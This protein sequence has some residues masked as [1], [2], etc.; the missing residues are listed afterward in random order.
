MKRNLTDLF[1]KTVD[2]PTDKRI[3]IY[4]QKIT[5]LTLRVTP[6]GK[7]TFTFTYRM[8]GNKIKRRLQ[9]G[10]YPAVLLADAREKCIQAMRD[11]NNNIDPGL[12]VKDTK[13]TPLIKDLII[14]F[15]ERELSKKKSGKDMLRILNKDAL[16]AWGTRKASSITRRDVVVLLD[17]VRDRGSPVAANRL[18][19]RL[20]RMFNFACE[21]GILEYSPIVRLRKTA[22]H[23]RERVLN[24]EEIRKFW[25]TIDKVGLHPL[26]AIA[27]KLILTTAQ[28]PGE[29]INMC[30]DEICMKTA[31]W[32]I[33]A[34]KSKNGR[35]HKVP[36]NSISLEL[37]QQAKKYSTNSKYVFPSPVKLLKCKPIEVRTLSRSINRKHAAIG[38]DKF[39]PHDLRRTVRTKFAK[40]KINDIVAERILNHSLQGMAR[41]YNQHDYLGEMGEALR[42]WQQHL[43]TIVS[44]DNRSIQPATKIDLKI[45]EEQFI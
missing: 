45:L 43:L 44:I 2:I 20:S 36:L 1:I 26:T 32:S 29:V 41:V 28:R 3:E 11:I 24:D 42:L 22:E 39:V 31:I 40:L 6:A 13:R 30:Y 21:R 9:I 7:K 5:G 35:L 4:D 14:E 23:H 12:G 19:G 16:P 8:P 27:L 34:E 33:P 10:T 37:L 17:K 18:H 25:L 15:W 38:I